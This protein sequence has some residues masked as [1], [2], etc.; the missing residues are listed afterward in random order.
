MKIYR[1]LKILVLSLPFVR[2]ILNGNSLKRID[3][4]LSI[5]EIEKIDLTALQYNQLV[6][7]LRNKA[8]TSN[9]KYF[10]ANFT[11]GLKLQQVPEE[12]ASLMQFVRSFQPKSYLEIGIGNGGS[13]F[14][15]SYFLKNSLEISHAV[16]NLSYGKQINQQKADIESI[17]KY[18]SSSISDVNFFHSSSTNFLTNC[19][20][21]YNVIFIDG[22]HSYEGVKSDYEFSKKLLHKEG[23]FIFHDVNSDNSPGV[24]KLWSEL[25]QAYPCYKEFVEGSTC[26]IGVLYNLSY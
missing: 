23:M 2:F 5:I 11:G 24:K 12:Y 26:G 21:K 8:G 7:W 15:M 9:K 10:K 1:Y 4:K 16:D 18:L 13:W 17:K 25:K 22:D 3:L 6:N 14:L 20:N 19:D